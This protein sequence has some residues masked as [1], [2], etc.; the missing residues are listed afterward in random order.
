MRLAGAAGGAGGG[1]GAVAAVA[2]RQRGAGAVRSGWAGRRRSRRVRC[3]PAPFSH[4]P[5]PAAV[6]AADAA[7]AVPAVG[8]GGGDASGDR[9]PLPRLL[10]PRCW[11][12]PLIGCCC[13]RRR[14]LIGREL[15]R[16]LLI[17]GEL[18]RCVAAT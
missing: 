13:S 17:G 9:R 10:P 16:W 15:S 18:S 4:S 7:A 1:V 14:L 6:V 8:G 2:P 11:R 5:A 3:P 12:Q